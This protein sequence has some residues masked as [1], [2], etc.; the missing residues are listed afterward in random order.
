MMSGFQ[1][2]LI[3]HHVKKSS[4]LSVLASAN[5]CALVIMTKA[6]RAGQVKTRLTP[7]LTR[8]EAAALN[9]CFLRDISAS[10]S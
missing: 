7:P 10:H 8:E 2:K 6:P 4:S 9:I 1:I 5:L 3:I